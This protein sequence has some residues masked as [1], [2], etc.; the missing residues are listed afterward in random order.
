[1]QGLPPPL[2]PLDGSTPAKRV[3]FAA[4]DEEQRRRAGDRGSRRGAGPTPRHPSPPVT[5]GAPGAA[6]S[7][8][9]RERRKVE[10]AEARGSFRPQARAAEAG[11]SSR[12]RSLGAPS[13]ARAGSGGGRRRRQERA[14]MFSGTAPR[15][16]RTDRPS[17]DPGSSSGGRSSPTRSRGG[18]GQRMARRAGGKKMS[19][20][21]KARRRIEKVLDGFREVSQALKTLEMDADVLEMD[22]RA[23]PRRSRQ[24]SQPEARDHWRRWRRWPD[25]RR[26]GKG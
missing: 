14:V 26:S 25:A 21:E 2:P 15:H 20:A 11:A 19:A 16:P 17:R 3:T 12:R 6:T 23:S 13:F 24:S 8:A 7:S 5:P 10:R 4:S 1:M 18:R 9:A 22:L